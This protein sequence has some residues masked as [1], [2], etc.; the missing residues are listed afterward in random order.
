MNVKVN[1]LISPNPCGLDK[2]Q[3]R[4]EAENFFYKLGLKPGENLVS[5]VKDKLN[6]TVVRLDRDTWV[7]NPETSIVYGP[8]NFEIMVGPYATQERERYIIAH[9]LGHYVLHSQYGKIPIRATREGS[10]RVEWEANWFAMGFLMPEN[11][12][13]AVWERTEGSI[14]LVAAHFDVAFKA[15]EVRAKALFL[16]D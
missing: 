5:V 15:C 13:R 2:K 12:F 9:E 7:S 1:K 3:I 4:I 14:I 11:E 10:G 8:N 16:L 6:S